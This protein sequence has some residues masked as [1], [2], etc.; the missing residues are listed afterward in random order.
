VDAARA[1][2]DE[3]DAIEASLSVFREASEVSCLNRQAAMAPV[4]VSPG[5]FTLLSLCRELHAATGGAFDPASTALSRCWGFLDRSP[6]R[7]ADEEIA[8]ARARSGMDKV[9]IDDLRRA[10][11]FAVS[12][13][14]R[15]G[16]CAW[17]FSVRG[18]IRL[19]ASVARMPPSAATSSQNARTPALLPAA[20]AGAAADSPGPNATRASPMS[21]RRFRA[22]LSRHRRSRLRRLA[23]VAAGEPSQ[24]RSWRTTAAS[25][26]VAVSPSKSRLPVSISHSTTPKAQMPIFED[27]TPDGKR[28]L[29]NVPVVARSSVGFHVIVNWP[30]LLEARRE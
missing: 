20:S 21:R 28:F 18:A 5:L 11:R 9:V 23:G 4:P 15:A 26:S 17:I 24:G 14:N 27:V 8:A 29:L 30:S 7:P 25:T 22:S 10:V 3:V 13:V 19:M 2:L 12:N 6:R 1:A 16:G